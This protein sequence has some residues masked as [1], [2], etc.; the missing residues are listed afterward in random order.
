MWHTGSP[1][2][3]L[4]A[5]SAA[6]TAAAAAAG[7]T[8]AHPVSAFSQLGCMLVSKQQLTEVLAGKSPARACQLRTYL[9]CLTPDSA[10]NF[11][12][13]AAVHKSWVCNTPP[14]EQAY[15]TCHTTPLTPECADGAV[16]LERVTAVHVDLAR[17]CVGRVGS[18]AN[19]GLRH[20]TDHEARSK[21]EAGA[22]AEIAYDST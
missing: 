15:N 4:L 2:Y 1:A 14:C 13:A 16:V 12:E 6:T 3:D 21:H 19:G 20:V 18:G 17:L 8:E 11:R 7:T 9:D 5:S 22:A 10:V